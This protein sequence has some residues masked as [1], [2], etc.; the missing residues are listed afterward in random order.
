MFEDIV[1]SPFLL[2]DSLIAPE[3]VVAA[4]RNFSTIGKTPAMVDCDVS[5]QVKRTWRAVGLLDCLHFLP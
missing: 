4:L 3:V 5:G 2:R 1:V